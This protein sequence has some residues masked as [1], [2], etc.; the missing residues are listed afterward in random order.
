M[1]AV[2]AAAGELL[3]SLLLDW[4]RLTLRA[5]M[6]LQCVCLPSLSSFGPTLTI[7]LSLFLAYH[8]SAETWDCHNRVEGMLTQ[9]YARFCLHERKLPS[10]GDSPATA[11]RAGTWLDA[12][13]SNTHTEFLAGAK[14]YG[15]NLKTD[16][17]SVTMQ[18]VI[19]TDTL[20]NNIRLSYDHVRRQW[21]NMINRSTNI[22]GKTWDLFPERKKKRVNNFMHS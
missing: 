17:T 20:A 3:I 22:H 2:K 5:E 10:I 13:N 9:L 4:N 8:S 15:R 12:W 18:G 11:W 16:S 1:S 7:F 21:S 14:K 6:N 19:R